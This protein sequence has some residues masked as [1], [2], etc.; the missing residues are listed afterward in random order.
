M[1]AIALLNPRLM[2]EAR[3]EVHVVQVIQVVQVVQV[4]EHLHLDPA[5]WAPECSEP[6]SSGPEVVRDSDHGTP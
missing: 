2:P 5:R 6:A 4:V 1:T 3:P